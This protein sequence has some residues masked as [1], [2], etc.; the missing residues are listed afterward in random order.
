MQSAVTLSPSGTKFTKL[1]VWLRHERSSSQ[2]ASRGFRPTDDAVRKHTPPPLPSPPTIRDALTGLGMNRT[3]DRTL[4]IVTVF[5]AFLS[6]L[7]FIFFSL[8]SFLNISSSP[9]ILVL[10]LFYVSFVPRFSSFPSYVSF[11]I[12]RFLSVEIPYFCT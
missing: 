1:R 8:H 4:K 11:S 6:C 3:A 9:S 2:H 10:S 12:F 5:L 7:F